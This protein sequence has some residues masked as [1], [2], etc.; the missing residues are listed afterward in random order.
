VMGGW[1]KAWSRCSKS[2]GGGEQ[3]K[4]RKIK[5]APMNKGNRCGSTTT[6]QPCNQQ[7][8]ARFEWDMALPINCEAQ[9]VVEGGEC[10]IGTG[11]KARVNSILTGFELGKSVMQLYAQASKSPGTCPDGWN[12]ITSIITANPISQ[13]DNF[14]FKKTGVRDILQPLAEGMYQDLLKDMKTFYQYK[15]QTAFGI[16][17]ELKTNRTEVTGD[18]VAKLKDVKYMQVQCPKGWF[19][20]N[21]R[22]KNDGS[23]QPYG[24]SR[25]DELMCIKRK[26]TMNEYDGKCRDHEINWFDMKVIKK[27]TRFTCTGKNLLAG[28]RADWRCQKK[29]GLSCIRSMK[30]CKMSFKKPQKAQK[31]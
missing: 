10:D 12:K 30:C 8:C 18:W 9:S 1:S 7:A 21:I 24:F 13:G 31:T 17:F 4:R 23:S 26:G 11:A 29:G 27:Q 6:T 3:Y 25:M 5:Q 15:N 20:N 14:D 19:I 28:F 2:C 16:T 22:V